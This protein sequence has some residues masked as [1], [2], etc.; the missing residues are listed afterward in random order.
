MSELRQLLRYEIPS[1]LFFIDTILIVVCLI[2][3]FSLDWFNK[4]TENNLYDVLTAFIA[5]VIVVSIPIGWCL[6]QTYDYLR[7]PHYIKDSIKLLKEELPGLPPGK[8][9]K[10]ESNY[11]ELLDMLLFNDKYDNKGLFYNI[12]NYWDHHDARYIAGYYVPLLAI[13]VASYIIFYMHVSS[14][15]I[16]W[17]PHGFLTCFNIFLVIIFNLYLIF[18]VFRPHNRILDEIDARERFL[19]LFKLRK[20]RCLKEDPDLRRIFDP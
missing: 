4:I 15:T 5:F 17:R 2:D 18:I 9:A 7:K 10:L 3:P 12:S 1:L 6:Y 13:S 19:I 11:E 20:I 14:G 8:R 16:P